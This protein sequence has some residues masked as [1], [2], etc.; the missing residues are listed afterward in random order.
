[1]TRIARLEAASGRWVIAGEPDPGH[2]R[3]APRFECSVC[4]K[5]TLKGYNGI[6][7]AI[8]LENHRVVC[9]RCC[10]R[11]AHARFFPVCPDDWHDLVDHAEHWG[12]NAAI[13]AILG[14]WPPCRGV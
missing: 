1:M 6:G 7:P 11:E 3:Q 14:I 4:G 8:L 12:T 13:A 5:P 2:P 10:T 9:H